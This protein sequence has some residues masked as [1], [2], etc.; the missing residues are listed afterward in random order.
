MS[1]VDPGWIDSQ[2]FDFVAKRGPG[3]VF[4]ADI[5]DHFREPSEA[6]GLA[7]DRVSVPL[8]RLAKKSF[9]ECWVTCPRGQ[10]WALTPY[11]ALSLGLE[12]DETGSRW[13]KAGKMGATQVRRMLCGTKGNRRK[14]S[15][16]FESELE[17]PEGF[18]VFID[19]RLEDPAES[20]VVHEEFLL[21]YGLDERGEDSPSQTLAKKH[22]S[23]YVDRPIPPPRELWGSGCL[24]PIAGQRREFGPPEG[25]EGR[26]RPCTLC[27]HHPT[28]LS[29]CLCC[30]S[31]SLDFR[32]PSLKAI[33]SE[34]EVLRAIRARRE[35]K[36]ARRRERDQRRQGGQGAA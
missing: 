11:A 33:D 17:D 2:V 14:D 7:M 36:E 13:I 1:N 21:A 12:L 9:L 20:I 34:E 6:D 16:F 22:Q 23:D 27:G 8:I 5:A 26:S 3:W 32:L 29:Y 10:A 4:A 18:D 25:Q 28:G 24:W 30:D 35:R 19:S 31:Y 15:Y